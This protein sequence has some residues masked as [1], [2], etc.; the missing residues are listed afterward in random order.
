M[1]L[2]LA[3]YIASLKED[4]ELD[5]LIEGILKEKDF[6]IIYGPQKGVRQYGV[7]IH[8][9]GKDPVDNIKK[10]FLI[11]VKQGNLNRKNWQEGIQA[12]EPSL[13]EII[14]VY[15]KNNISP[16]HR[17]LPI[18]IVIAHNGINEAA[19][20]QNWTAFQK[21]YPEYGFDIWQL[22]TLVSMVSD[23]MLNERIFSETAREL[24]RKVI[25]NLYNPEYDLSHF[26]LLLDH[27]IP[28]H[29][30]EG[31]GSKKERVKCL[32]KI[33]LIMAIVFSY[34]K[35]EKDSILAIKAGEM[36]LL[37]VWVHFW[38]SGIFSDPPLMKAFID[39]L[40]L[41]N[42]INQFYLSRILPVC[43][44]EDGFGKF[45]YDP[46]AYNSVVYAHLGQIA[47]CGI[48]SSMLENLFGKSDQNLKEIFASVTI[49]AAN[50]VVRLFENNQI[51]ST[52]DT[53]DR[54]I[55]INLAFTL[56]F[57]L[58]RK[59]DVRKM[60]GEYLECMADAK[61]MMNRFP[62]F[63]NSLEKVAEL[64]AYP[65]L[66]DL[67]ETESSSLL[68]CLIEWT[69][70]ADDQEL[71]QKA[72][73]YLNSAFKEINLLLWFPDQDT[74]SKFFREK[75][76]PATGY[77]LTELSFPEDFQT[78]KNV[79]LSDYLHNAQECKFGFIKTGM[80]QLG[81]IASLHFRTF[82]FPYYWRRLIINFSDIESSN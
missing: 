81:M 1:K 32:H 41:K 26:A 75:A 69:A 51:I 46:I 82:I 8:T 38:Q 77:S 63:G 5:I 15:I 49:A 10:L 78:F 44:I 17:K 28:F 20:Q 79:V 60:I 57:I 16:A 67:G 68:A 52:P 43:E 76:V 19:I 58:D 74:E 56:L 73:I 33:N 62:D 80:W 42:R 36:T 12:L 72:L 18:V 31:K 7:D 11:T 37:K 71:Y 50:G 21:D 13:R 14:S 61:Y 48:E 4:R 70:V 29:G 64:Q 47:L 9:I 66:R 23:S 45:C 6:E 55:E 27:I 2:I 30:S 65:E 40:F 59:D 24:L 34:C 25:V 39:L 53:D 54:M 35:R 3:D 22:D